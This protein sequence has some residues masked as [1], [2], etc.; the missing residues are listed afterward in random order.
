MAEETFVCDHCGN[1]FPARQMKELAY[2]K[3][4]ERVTEHVCPS[5]LDKAMNESGEVR[6]IAGQD[7]TA[8]AHL[9][10]PPS[11]SEE[12]SGSGGTAS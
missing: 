9:D 10:A 12:G 7:K 6:G 1:Q 11:A 8:A 2:E 4:A 5:C 3:G